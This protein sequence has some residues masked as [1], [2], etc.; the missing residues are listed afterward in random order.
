MTGLESDEHEAWKAAF[1]IMLFF[2]L[3]SLTLRLL[4]GRAFFTLE[5]E[6]SLVHIPTVLLLS[7]WLLEGRKRNSGGL[8]VGLKG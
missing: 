2:S 5:F 7:V 6:I 4:F 3:L 8:G 1:L